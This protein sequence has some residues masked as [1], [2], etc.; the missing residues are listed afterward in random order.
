[1]KR[2]L[3]KQLALVQII[4][5]VIPMIGIIQSQLFQRMHL[6]TIHMLQ[7]YSFQK[8]WIPLKN[9]HSKDVLLLKR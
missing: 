1:M 9:L 4:A 6:K 8:W 5:M 2:F 7:M 3:F